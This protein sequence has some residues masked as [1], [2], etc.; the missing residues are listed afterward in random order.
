MKISIIVPVY[1][2]EEY[3]PRC[4]DSILQQSFSSY[5]LLLIDDGSEDQSGTLCDNYAKKDS[6]I[7]VIHQSN[8]GQ[9]KARNIGIKLARGEWVC[10]VDSDDV[11]HPQML[12]RL[13]YA[14]IKSNAGISM[15]SAIESDEIRST[16]FNPIS[17]NYE[18]YIVNEQFLKGLLTKS[19]YYWVVWAK[20]IQKEIVEKYPFEVGRVYEDNEVV[21]K[22]L[23]YAGKVAVSS[24]CLYFYYSNSSGTTKKMFSEKQFDYLWALQEQLTFYDQLKYSEMWKAIAERYIFDGA[25]L[26]LR[27]KT[28]LGKCVEVKKLKKEICYFAIYYNNNYHLSKHQQLELFLHLQ[29]SIKAVYEKGS[30]IKHRLEN[31]K[32]N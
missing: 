17:F 1:N 22:W 32:D 18:C 20:L 13:Y 8:Q 14:A 28:E 3:L 7:K 5:E 15:C 9:A 12:E 21:C 31:H 19:Y 24:Q 11:I 16:F 6:R 30:G 2:V 10:F 27:A 23:Y 26:L 4:I 29:P 25:R